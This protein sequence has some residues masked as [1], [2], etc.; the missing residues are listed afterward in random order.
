VFKLILL[1]LAIELGKE[2][3]DDRPFEDMF[4]VIEVSFLEESTSPF[5]PLVVVAVFWLSPAVC[6][7]VLEILLVARLHVLGGVES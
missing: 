3:G 5:V 2:V 7:R 4:R 1:V 6:L